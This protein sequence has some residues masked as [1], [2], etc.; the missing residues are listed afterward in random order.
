MFHNSINIKVLPLILIRMLIK[1][2]LYLTILLSIPLIYLYY[3]RRKKISG[4]NICIIGGTSGFGFSLAKYSLTMENNVT[5]TSRKY[6]NLEKTKDKLSELGVNTKNLTCRI[7]DSLS[8]IIS[9]DESFDYVF[10]CPGISIPGYFRNQNEDIFDTQLRLNYLGMIRSL[11]HF[12]KC[13]R[14]PHR[15]V[16]ISSTAALFPFAGYSSYAPTKACLKAFY[17]SARYE[18]AVEN[19][20]LKILYC[21]SMKTPGLQKENETKPEFTR[22]IEYTNV[23]VEP[24]R[25][26]EYFMETIDKRGSHS[27]DWFT[28]F[29]MIRNECECLIDYLLF[30]MAVIIVYISREYIRKEF[31]KYKIK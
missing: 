3:T 10:Y 4:K 19:V 20:D 25:M 23:V 17:E 18:L 22:D 8:D 30:P 26:V 7:L 27:Y 13:N 9:V 6:E 15:F 14:I 11:Y 29:F 12:K 28:Y 2:V 5:I 16:L 24:E 31:Q 1:S 21:C